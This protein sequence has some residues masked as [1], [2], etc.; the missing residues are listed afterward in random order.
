MHWNITLKGKWMYERGDIRNV[1]KLVEN[2]QL[3]IGEEVSA[4]K[5]RGSFRLDQWEEAFETAAAVAADGHVVL[6]P[7]A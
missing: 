2:G 5:C 1:I 6:T 3:K 4:F 7:G